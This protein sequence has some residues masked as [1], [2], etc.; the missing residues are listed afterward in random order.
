MNR[1]TEVPDEAVLLNDVPVV[2][3][4]ADAVRAYA[5]AMLRGALW[6]GVAAAVLGVVVATVLVG[7]R[8]LAGSLVGAALGLGGSLFTLHVMRRSAGAEPM[9]LMGVAMASFFAKLVVFG[10][11]ALLLG[12]LPV[13]HPKALAL[14]M[15]GTVLAWTVGEV[16]GFRRAKVPTI[17][18]SAER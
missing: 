10:V 8:G 3:T 7:E 4:P 6:P 17:I 5:H 2:E 1:R 11:V 9:L 16:R 13:F 14:V 15:L 12:K 18:P